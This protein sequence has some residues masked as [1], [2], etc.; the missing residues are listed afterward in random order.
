MILWLTGILT[1]I[2]GGLTAAARIFKFGPWLHTKDFPED[3]STDGGEIYIPE[4]PEITPTSVSAPERVYDVA[5]SLLGQKLGDNIDPSVACAISVS[6]VLIRAGYNN[7]K[8]P[9]VNGLISWMVSNGFKEVITPQLGAI[10]TAHSVNLLNPE[11]AH[12]GVCGKDW[13]LSNTSFDGPN[14]LKK[15]TFQANYQFAGWNKAF[16]KSKTRYFL[17]V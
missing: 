5:K 8:I 12:C 13:I 15:G 3:L 11:G 1:V 10:I 14:G 2:L 16:A 7:P 17:P 9:T 6:N 4:T